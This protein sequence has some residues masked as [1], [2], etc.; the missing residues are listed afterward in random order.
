MLLR[1]E[2][3]YLRKDGTET[4]QVTQGVL[5]GR[6]TRDLTLLSVNV[7]AE[8]KS[9]AGSAIAIDMGRNS[10]AVFIDVDFWGRMAENAT[11]VLKKG[12]LVVL[13]GNL[14]DNSYTNKEGKEVKR[15]LLQVSNWEIIWNARPK[16]NNAQEQQEAPVEKATSKEEMPMDPF[17]AHDGAVAPTDE[18]MEDLLNDE[19]FLF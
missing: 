16:N 17:H 14:K 19:D 2:I 10:Q 9:V 8:T 3:K 4:N 5:V 7:G 15:E 18:G 1:N 12:D 11:K 13:V 6:L